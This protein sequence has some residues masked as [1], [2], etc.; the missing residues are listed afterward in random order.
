MKMRQITNN[1]EQITKGRNQITKGRGL[2]ALLFVS[3]YLLS[4][5]AA[6]ADLLEPPKMP[7]KNDYG[8]VSII[9][10]ESDAASPTKRTV[11]PST[12]FDRYE[13]T[14]TKSGET[15]GEVKTPDNGSFI[16]EVGDYTVAVKAYIG[17]AESYTLAASGVSSQFIVGS[18]NNTPV[19][20]RLSRVDTEEPGTFKYT[21]TYPAGAAMEITLK[22]W[23]ELTTISLSPENITLGNGNG[24][25][26]T[27][28][29]LEAGSY[30]LTVIIKQ[31]GKYAGKNEAVHIYP[32]N[33]TEYT[34]DFTASDLLA[35]I[36]PTLS[37][38]ATPLIAN[39]W[40]NGTVSANGEQW[41]M[42]IATE[43][44]QY[45][46]TDF[47]TLT[48]LNVQVYGSSGSTV[49]S[50]T[51][52]SN[53][54][55][56]ISRSV[57][58]GQVYYIQVTP[59]SNSS[60]TYQIAFN[61]S[62]TPPS[63]SSSSSTIITLTADTWAN[64]TV[65][66]NGE[67]W[68]N[69]TATAAT[70][71]I[72]V[73]FGTLS[74]LYVQLYDSTGST[75][76][77]RTNLSSSSSSSS[78]KY[79]S[80]TVTT[81]QVYYIRVTPY[82]SSGTYQIA[83]NST[84][85]P[86]I[87][88]TLTAD[89]WADGN[90]SSYGEQWFKFTATAAAQNIH[91]SFGTLDSSYGLNVQVYNSNGST[92]GDQTR[93]YGSTRNISQTV[94]TGQVYY[95]RVTPYSSGGTYQIAFNTTTRL[96]ITA[97]LTADTWANG[98]LSSSYSEQWFRFTATASTQYI[99][100]NFGTLSS[101]Y[102]QVYDSNYST[103][104]S[105][106][107]LNSDSDTK[108]I[109][110]SLASG[111]A[112]YIRVMPYSSSYAGTYQIAFNTTTMPPITATLTADTWADG[113]LLSNG[114]QWFKFTATA[115]T[116]YIH[117]SFGTLS[118]SNGLYV[119]VYDSSYNTVGSK[120][121]L[122]S[123]ATNTSQSVTNDDVYYIKVTPYNS[124]YSGTYQIAFNT[125]WSPPGAA[126]L[127]ADTWADGT[128]SANGVQ[129]FRFTATAAAQQYIHISFGTLDSSNGLYVQVYNSSGSTV[130]NQTRL[131]GS[132]RNISQTVTTGEVYY[133]KVTPYSS[134]YSGTYKIAFNSI[135][136]PPGAAALTADTWADG[137]LPSSGEQWFKF[138]ATA[139]TQY[140]HAS[141]GTLNPSYGLYVQVYDS[142][143][144]TVGSQ[145]RLYSSATNT[146]RS[147]TNDDVY[148]IKVTPYNSSYSGTYKIA[149]NT[150]TR[151]PV[152][153]TLTADT[154]ADGNLISSGE[155]WFKFTAKATTQNIHV[156]FG[157]LDSSNGLYVQ[158]YDSSY[159]TV[160]SQ[161]NLYGST[162]YTS[163]SVTT[164][165]VYYIKVTP[166]YSGYSGTYQIA[167]ND[168]RVPPGTVVTT[169]TADTWADGN[170]PSSGEQWFKFTATASTQYIH[171]SF[172]TL[173]SSYG[174]LNVQ[175]YNSS[176]G[177]VGSQTRL[178]SSTANISRTV[179]TGQVYYIRVTPY[180][181]S[182][183]G[184][185]KI[186]FN[187]TTRP[188]VTATL[189]A[190]TWADGN[191]LSNGEQWFKFTA[192]A[193]TQ[194]IHANF[195][196]LDSSYGLNVQVYNSS[197]NTVGSQDNLSSSI[198]YITQTLTSGQVYYIQVTPYYS[199]YSGTYKIAFNTTWSP[200][201]TATL[202]ADT[203]ADGN[204]PSNGE[205][206]F[207]FT[208]TASTQYIHASLG[209]LSS[210]GLYVQVYNSNGSTV[211][212]QTRLYSDTKYITR[213]VTSGQVYYIKVTPYSS[214]YSG[215]YKIAFNAIW[216]PPGTAITTLTAGTWTDGNLP[217][218]SS[219]QWFKFTATAST[220]YINVNFGT[221]NSSNGLNVQVYNS[222][223]NI[224]GSQTQ[225]YSS[226]R[227]TNVS[228]L[229]SGQVYYIQVTPS[230]S[231]Y[232]GTYQIAFNSIWSPA[233][234][235]VTTL[236]AGTWA[237]GN[238]SLSGSGSVQ[239]FRFTATAATQYIN[240]NFGT[241]N[242]SNGLNVQVYNSGG[243]QVGYETN[244]N[245]STR[246]TSLSSATTGQVYYIRI[247][248][249]SSGYSGTYQIAF[250][251]TWSPIGVTVTTLTADTWA[252]GNLTSNG[253]Q[254]FKF[255][256]TASTQYIHVNF[257]TLN[258]SNG[259]YIQ[260]YNSSGG[261]VGSQTQLYSSN[262]YT[263]VSSL[264]SGQ[265]Y[266][267][268]VTPSYSSYSGTYQI[269]FNTTT[270]PPVAATLTANTWANG[271]FTSSTGEQWFKFTATASPQYIHVSFGTLISYYGLSGRVCDSNNNTL[272]YFYFDSSTY[273]SLSLTS[274]QVYYIQVTPNYSYST[275]TYKIAFNTSATTPPLP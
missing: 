241:L 183:S 164:D 254:W 246:Y 243:Y 200:P 7:V 155:Q 2:F 68:F 263:N 159:N 230:Y 125:T 56:Y 231:S 273:T 270:R 9:L 192:T 83:F 156:N 80:R 85:K 184:T 250:N 229:T 12:V 127:T 19:E 222:S 203:W 190:D 92:V 197:G 232:S 96:P 58:S 198:R 14:F 211:G 15:D 272:H 248:P 128:V 61:T 63:S 55:K 191:I 253:E 26:Q 35:V 259:L 40:A 207:K 32:L 220:Q 215:T 70:Q 236:T 16:L 38:P 214:G 47:D 76:G 10:T 133:I 209:T 64:G 202:T 45:I 187:T 48:S 154:W 162:R 23:P 161:T 216:L 238:F 103:A 139:A 271:N 33:F 239:W 165:D 82:S 5:L 98:N 130:V 245:S 152:T 74:N 69:F 235:N 208:A 59:G 149:F 73:N 117:A 102:V 21:I 90:I 132:T 252:D 182:Y 115:A 181:S 193:S 194:Y 123:S 205:Q 168:L 88:A 37:A 146:S 142:S 185:Y 145:T 147:V 148:Y 81:G 233:G 42:F 24:Q 131:Y 25:T 65:S 114:E 108:Y 166:N 3:C 274:G 267:I 31:D 91:I 167:F 179:T 78:T 221:L 255:T 36:P 137:N 72:H 17:D 62:S 116:Q 177:T 178:Y 210:N 186:A 75:I 39:A 217:S 269:A 172:G 66:A 101:L 258:S 53:S 163:L 110:Q 153:A 107:R 249:Y 109:T 141:F 228:S 105:Q 224:V 247:T 94:T 28:D 226:N 204:L 11:L 22:K 51:S 13:Y 262:R 218:S 237:D 160:G 52:L 201:I 89:T 199:S 244:L 100:A 49:G 135:Q 144:N 119:Q 87:T 189:T 158:V 261:T 6:C 136:I 20:V 140:I 268:K 242:S 120:T 86:P 195:G 174:G 157:T 121:R 67:Q 251:S 95:I 18:G 219:E 129:W 29:D 196:T 124:S 126:A 27:L 175:V 206:W 41:F 234:V 111:Q 170:L 223:N 30:L 265:V 44:T 54:N 257:G 77:S 84:D 169:L 180:S 118:A 104:G 134:S 151:P 227:Y 79:I 256:A 43:S 71:Y 150:I 266:Y 106:V 176:G 112:Y 57:T 173:N 34:K 1:R 240:V 260:M 188:P 264:T 50:Q 212:D 143:Y 46:H 97:T 122:Y 171:A 60:G 99:H 113:N 138:T 275:G 213:T 93:L 8:R 225:L 4:V